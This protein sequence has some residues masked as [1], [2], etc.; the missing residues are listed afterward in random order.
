MAASGAAASRGGKK[1]AGGCVPARRDASYVVRRVE[2]EKSIPL[3]TLPRV[4]V[5]ST[6]VSPHSTNTDPPV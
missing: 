1:I 4:A 5:T 3:A 2:G 6:D